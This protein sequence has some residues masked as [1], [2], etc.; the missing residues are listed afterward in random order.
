MK[1]RRIDWYPVDWLDGVATMPP[2]QRGVY[3]TIINLIYAHA[4]DD[5]S[6]EMSEHELAMRC[7]CHWRELRRIVRALSDS[8]KVIVRQSC[9]GPAGLLRLSC[10][11]KRCAEE[12]Q[13]ARTRV[14]QAQHNGAKGGRPNGLDKPDGSGNENLA[15]APLI[16]HHTTNNKGDSDSG[17]LKNMPSDDLIRQLANVRARA[18][19][20]RNRNDA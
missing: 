7:C 1:P 10:T 17:G 20:R 6:I 11:V 9:D 4:S 15:R 18:E 8:H 14:A 19:A 2:D 13:K 3:D 16:N 12:L 5:A